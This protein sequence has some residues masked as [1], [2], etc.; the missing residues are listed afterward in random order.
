MADHYH[1]S[2]FTIP[3]VEVFP[4]PRDED[5]LRSLQ[6][7]YETRAQAQIKDAQQRIAT[8][9][10]YLAE[11]T[12]M[13][14]AFSARSRKGIAGDNIE[15]LVQCRYNTHVLGFLGY[16]QFDLRFE[17]LG[18][19]GGL[20][21]IL[22][23][24]EKV[25]SAYFDLRSLLE[26]FNTDTGSAAAAKALEWTR[27]SAQNIIRDVRASTLSPFPNKEFY[28]DGDSYI[29]HYLRAMLTTLEFAH[30]NFS[31]VVHIQMIPR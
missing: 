27:R 24:P 17:K 4:L 25:D 15:K 22:D 12:T 21:S 5:E 13:C 16:S 19:G 26:W 6:L 30:D 31:S 20:V 23:H 8:R 2:T 18:W 29:F 7:T 14:L 10:W 9:T 3:A 1:S 11:T 28:S